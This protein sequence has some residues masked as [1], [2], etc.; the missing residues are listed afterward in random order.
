MLCVGI[1]AHEGVDVIK[2]AGIAL[3]ICFSILAIVILAI[4]L[5]HTKGF[6]KKKYF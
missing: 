6:T 1:N 2:N 5:I 4:N 3:A